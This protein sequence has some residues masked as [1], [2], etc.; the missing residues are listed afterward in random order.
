MTA[1]GGEARFFQGVVHG[2]GNIVEGINQGSVQIKDDT[3][4]PHAPSISRRTVF[5]KRAYRIY[6]PYTM[7]KNL[8]VG[9]PALL[10]VSFTIPLLIGNLF[11]QFYSMA[12]TFIVGRT[13]GVAALAAVGCTGSLSFL[14]LGFVMGFT[15]GTAIITAQRFGAGDEGGVRRSFAVS[16]VLCGIMAVVLTTISVI[17]TG[18]ILRLLR[19]PEEIFGGA[20]RYIIIIFWGTGVLVMFNLLS[21]VMRAVGDSRTPLVVLV[22]ACLVNIVLDYVFILVFHT[23]V[24]G[25]AY[26]TLIAQVLSCLLC[27]LIIVKKIS[28]LRIRKEDWKISKEDMVEHIRVALP[29]GFQMSIIA[30]GTVVLQFALNRL[31]TTAVAAFTAAQKID[32]VATM[33]MHSFGVTMATFTAQN[34]GARKFDRIRAGVTQS[35]LVSGSF[36]I[37]MGILFFLTGNHLSGVFIGAEAEAVRLAHIYLKI[38]GSCY[39]LLAFLFIFRNT[40]QGLGDSLIPTVAGIMELVM[41][42]LA[43]LILPAFF[44][45]AGACFAGPLAWLGASVPLT[46][47]LILTMKKLIRKSLAEKA[48]K[49]ARDRGTR[50]P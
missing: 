13:I 8:T 5:E 40:L 50:T 3:F 9:N 22:F 4:K 29:M 31:G 7:T 27:A 15:S 10:I 34:Y 24:E 16:I 33:P 48:A 14:F 37:F 47:A 19:T 39:I 49:I 45:F 30:I 46:I 36:S 38:N 1:E 41:R 43:A 21:N 25:A 32:M 26:A 20:Y 11:Q 35:S 23:G 12:D 28:V 17:F 2:G 42:T 6:Y 44:G 18:P